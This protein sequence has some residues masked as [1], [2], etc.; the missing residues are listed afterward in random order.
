[1]KHIIVEGC[2][3][4]GKTGL[5]EELSKHFNL[6]RHLRASDSITGPVKNLR[7]WVERDL[8]YLEGSELDPDRWTYIYDRH[9]LIS[10]PIYANYRWVNPGLADGFDDEN[11]IRSTTKDMG[12]LSILVICSPPYE[13]VERVLQMQGREAHMPGVFEN[14]FSIWKR[15]VTL[16]WPGTVIRYD[17]TRETLEDLIGTLEKMN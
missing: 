11:W 12:S 7:D 17:R 8:D 2:D 3:G 6:V 15:Y 5:I 16:C 4:S 14:R 10:E 1:M 13:E 9:P